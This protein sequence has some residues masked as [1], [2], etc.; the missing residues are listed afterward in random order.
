MQFVHERIFRTGLCLSVAPGIVD[1]T[2]IYEIPHDD[3][4]MG[5][6]L[7]T[8]MQPKRKYCVYHKAIL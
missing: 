1:G 6:Q 3:A 7:I 2:M 8:S 4:P 5:L